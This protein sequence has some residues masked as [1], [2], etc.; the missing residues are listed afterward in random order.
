MPY[1][2]KESTKKDVSPIKYKAN[3]T[4]FQCFG[5]AFKKM[6]ACL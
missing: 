2:E 4:I 5:K 1:G 3:S 6:T